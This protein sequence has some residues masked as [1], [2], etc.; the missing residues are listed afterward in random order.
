[1]PDEP[2][3][4]IDLSELLWRVLP[5]LAV[6]AALGGFPTWKWSGNSGLVAE[7]AATVIAAVGAVL[8]GGLIRRAAQEGPARATGSFLPAEGYRVAWCVLAALGSWLIFG[9]DL[10]ALVLWTAIHFLVVLFWLV[11]WLAAALRRDAR[12]VEQGRI[13]RFFYRSSLTRRSR[14]DANEIDRDGL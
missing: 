10:V 2:A 4:E 5:S 9:C 12:L 1:M 13:L 7:A 6:V 11:V 8:T 3:M 14:P